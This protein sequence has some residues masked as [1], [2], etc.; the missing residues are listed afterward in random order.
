MVRRNA[1]QGLSYLVHA[2]NSEKEQ[3]LKQSRREIKTFQ[4]I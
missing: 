4:T 3:A 2:L 1:F